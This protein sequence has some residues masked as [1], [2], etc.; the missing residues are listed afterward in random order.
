MAKTHTSTDTKTDTKGEMARSP[1]SPK[2]TSPASRLLRRPA[3][4]KTETPY[5]HG[6]L[7][8]ALLEAAE[9][10]LERMSRFGE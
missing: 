1:R 2:K 9:R 4:A 10:V 5:H 3:A 7:R 6:A 8:E